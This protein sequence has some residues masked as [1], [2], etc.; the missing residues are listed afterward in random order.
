MP[1]I[2]LT[3]EEDAALTAAARKVLDED[4]YP[5]SPRLAL[6]S[7]ARPGV[8]AQAEAR[9]EAAVAGSKDP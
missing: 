2:D 1:R 6:L 4:R 7:E 5:M 8:G 3:D 9:A